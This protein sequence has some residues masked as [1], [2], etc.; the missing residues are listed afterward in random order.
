MQDAILRGEDD[1][2]EPDAWIKPKENFSSAEQLNVYING[3]R[4]R[5]YNVTAEDFPILKYAMGEEAFDTFLS[6]FVN[7][8]HSQHF[9]IA[10]YSALL[11]NFLA[12][13][14]LNTPF[15]LEIAQVEAAISQLADMAETTALT[16]EHLA[17][18]TPDALM[19]RQLLPRAALQ[20]FK[21]AY[22]VNDYYMAV[23]NGDAPS[24]P[25]PEA[26]HLAVFRHEDS[27]WR[28]E[29]NE[30][31]YVLL[32][33]LFDGLPVGQ[34]L[35]KTQAECGLDEEALPAQLSHWFSRW[36]RNGLLAATELDIE[37]MKRNAA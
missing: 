5:L 14:D 21:L 13:H 31:E 22:P 29:L 4:Y 23:K 1:A 25:A 8:V 28:M 10:R 32:H 26:S 33:N 15:F 17:G 37:N 30:H 24:I 9:N 36:M 3:Y 7:N 19:E 35:E 16:P 2:N 12:L 18:M 6:D 34:A 11:P 27:V 20:L